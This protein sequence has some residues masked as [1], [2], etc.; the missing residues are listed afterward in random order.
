MNS[1]S[2]ATPA[3]WSPLS[4]VR[5]PPPPSTP[6]PCRSID[7]S[8]A[9]LHLTQQKKTDDGVECQV[10]K[11]I[12]RLVVSYLEMH[13]VTSQLNAYLDSLCQETPAVGQCVQFVDTY[14]PA[15]IAYIKQ[16]ENPQTICDQQLAVC[17]AS[18]KAAILN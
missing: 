2:A 7:L 17:P 5:R 9:E 6:A 14:L 1:T 4:R 12:V 8:L 16:T 13:Q 11:F 3:A 15:V 18:T 10:C